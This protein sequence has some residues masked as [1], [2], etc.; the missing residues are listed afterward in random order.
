MLM[1]GGI[2]VSYGD[3]KIIAQ[4]L[5]KQK[6]QLHTIDNTVYINKT[7]Y[8]FARREFEYGFSMVVPESFDDMPSEIA[9]QK[10]PHRN[11]PPV[12]ISS[13]DYRVC[14]AFNQ[15]EPLAS[16]M[17]ALTL[18]FRS[19]IKSIRPANVFFSY[20]AYDLPNSMQVS[21]FDYRYSI[22]NG[23][24]YNITFLANLSDTGLFGGFICPVDVRDDWEPL[25]RQMLKTIEV[26]KEETIL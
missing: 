8:T 26:T 16:D 19:Y 4:R 7:E 17:D 2:A 22:V 5:A 24:L 13:S 1:M 15:I 14:L 21:H 18:Q 3:E 6:E 20:G 23:D 25:V 9:D 12:I 10:F 11:R